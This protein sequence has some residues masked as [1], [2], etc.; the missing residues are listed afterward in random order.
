[1]RGIWKYGQ[2]V[3]LLATIIMAIGYAGIIVVSDFN[4]RSDGV[5]AEV[6]SSLEDF[7]AATE[8]YF[9]SYEAVIA[10]V[11]ETICVRGRGQANCGDLFSR[12]NHR[13]PN[14]VN[15]AAID[16]DGRFFASGQP[17]PASGPPDASN[18]PFFAALA[19]EDRHL[20]VMDPHKGPVSGELVTG[21]V[22]P[23][24]DSDGKFDGVAGVSL[25]FAELQGIWARIKPMSDVGIII[26]DRR[27]ALIFSSP[28]AQAVAEASDEDRARLFDS[29]AATEGS[30]RVGGKSWVFRRTQAAG[31]D[32]IIAAIHPGP[33]DFANYLR[34]TSVLPKLL[35]P[36]M[37]LGLLGLVL[38]VR[39]WRQ[40]FALERQVMER[41]AELTQANADLRRSNR[42]MAVAMAEMETFTWVASH[43]LRE[44]LRAVS[45]YVTMLE[46]RYGDRLDDDGR[47]F[48]AYAREGAQRMNDLVLDLLEYVGVGGPGGQIKLVDVEAVARQALRDL[49]A[50]RVST[51][52]VATVRSPMPSLLMSESDLVRLFTNL[53]VNAITYRHPERPPEVALAA[54]WGDAGW[55]FSVADNGIGIEPQY[56]EKIFQLFQRLDPRA[57]AESTGIGLAVCRKVVDRYGGRIWV[58]SEPG[59]GSRFLFTL[60]DAMP[61]DASPVA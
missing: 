7:V 51:G 46:R 49:E 34:D 17:F 47:Q 60:P 19:K 57:D 27:R 2:S 42:D 44:P 20:Y 8:A 58:E 36:V 3:V 32:W 22:L 28:E 10:A 23:L 33:Y 40:R 56:F 25:R 43:D 54:E 41:T 21:L 52:C 11:G 5:R 4:V 12:L 61:A 9:A 30:V 18:Y 48:V 45:T 39:D 6:R 29:L 55:V 26:F 14:V 35:V 1:M 37:L 16:R 38:S 59:T 50:L 15:F 53:V 24:K 13:F 31:N